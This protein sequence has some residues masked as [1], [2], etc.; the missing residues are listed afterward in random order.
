VHD[1]RQ[2]EYNN[3]TALFTEE[4]WA[5]IKRNH[6][7]RVVTVPVCASGVTAAGADLCN[8]VESPES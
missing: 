3:F 5:V 8:V 4:G 1:S 7:S 2:F 6:D